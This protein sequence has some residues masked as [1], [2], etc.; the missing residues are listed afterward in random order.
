MLQDQEVRPVGGKVSYKTNCR[1]VAATNRIPTDAIK[2]GKLREDLFYRISA[3]SDA[4]ARRCA[5][6]AR[7][8]CRWRMRF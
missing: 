4:P 3:I 8:S 1:L 5:S 7:T 2:D 6:G